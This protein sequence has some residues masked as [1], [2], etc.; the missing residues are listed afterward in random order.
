MDDV[1][2]VML[3]PQRMCDHM[4]GPIDVTGIDAEPNL[5]IPARLNREMV[6][7]GQ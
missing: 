1:P 2:C 3:I 7:A 6:E 4:G 5:G